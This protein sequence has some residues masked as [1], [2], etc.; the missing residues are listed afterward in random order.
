M[1]CL[2]MRMLGLPVRPCLAQPHQGRVRV[3]TVDLRLP[4][5]PVASPA[6]EERLLHAHPLRLFNYLRTRSPMP[7][8]CRGQVPCCVSG[9]AYLGT[10]A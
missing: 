4:P 2:G 10:A 3:R 7:A 6:R 8:L 9:S 5:T 1:L